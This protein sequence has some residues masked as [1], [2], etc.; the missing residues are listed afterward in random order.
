MT[1]KVAALKNQL[2]A[3]IE[4]NRA[5]LQKD[6]QAYLSL[7]DH[8]PPSIL[9]YH[10][11]SDGQI[12]FYADFTREFG[13]DKI[14]ALHK[15]LLLELI[16][17][18]PDRVKKLKIPDSIRAIFGFELER[19]FNLV[20]DGGDFNFNWANDLFAKDMAIATFRL[21]PVGPALIEISGYSRRV[22]INETDRII[23][24][25][26]FYLFKAKGAFPF[27]EI[28]THL[29]NLKEF[30]PDGWHQVYL[31]VA[32]LL[33]LNPEIKGLERGSWLVDPALSRVS[34]RLEYLRLVPCANGARIFFIREEGEK[35]GAFST[36]QTRRELHAAGKYTPRSFLLVW[37]RKD[38]L[39]YADKSRNSPR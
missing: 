27:Y 14:P 19:I 18:F 10:H 36:S 17:R 8:F 31:R 22:L 1:D 3:D 23:G 33:R 26:W 35:S 6:I 28:H 4:I 15:I 13:A 37:P 29:A 32:D 38:L 9:K 25:L 30:N 5:F 20:K 39:D 12:K 2:E 34:P 7:I 11:L 24:N 16:G 21:I